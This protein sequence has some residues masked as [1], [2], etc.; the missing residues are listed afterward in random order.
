MNNKKVSIFDKLS[1]RHIESILKG[2]FLV[3]LSVSGNYLEQ[4]LGCHSRIL[5]DT[6]MIVKHIFVLFIIYFAIDLTQNELINPFYNLFKA[7]VVWILFHLF[8]HMN[9]TMTLIVFIL[10]MVLFFISNYQSYLDTQ[11]LTDDQY[12]KY[13]LKKTL[14][15]AQTILFDLI[16]VLLFIG[17]LLYYMRKRKEYKDNFDYIKYIFGVNKCKDTH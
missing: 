2:T 6:N 14:G 5:L 7:F 11:K 8:T 16:I 3:I 9:L 1:N 13:N 12:S 15:N 10:L 4:T 17:S